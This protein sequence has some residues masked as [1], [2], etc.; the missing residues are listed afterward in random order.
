VRHSDHR[1]KRPPLFVS[2][3][4]HGPRHR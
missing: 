1:V 2:G 3:T 4:P